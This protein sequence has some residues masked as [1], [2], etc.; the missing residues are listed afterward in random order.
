[1]ERGCYSFRLETKVKET[2][3][4]KHYV[5]EFEMQAA[6]MLNIK[7][8]KSGGIYPALALASLAEAA[9][10]PCQ[11]GSMVE[12]AIGT[13][14]GTHLAMSRS[15]IETNEMEGPLMFLRDVAAVKYNGDVIQ[16][17]DRPGLGTEVD[18]EYV[19]EITCFY[20]EI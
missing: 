8:M 16:F 17:S 4:T 15:I 1:M 20:C 19:K 18:E 2:Y 13:M 11:V 10:M 12:S 5:V 3:P 7:P 9:E 6:D 14:A